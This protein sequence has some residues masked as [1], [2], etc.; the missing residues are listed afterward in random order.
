MPRVLRPRTTRSQQI[1]EPESEDSSFILSNVQVEIY[2]IKKEDETSQVK[3]EIVEIET[4]EETDDDDSL[5]EGADPIYIPTRIYEEGEV[6]DPEDDDYDDFYPREKK[7]K[8]AAERGNPNANATKQ[9]TTTVYKWEYVYNYKKRK[10]QVPNPCWDCEM[11]K[12]Q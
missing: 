12:K 9:R 11:V 7:Y 8:K 2:E 6:R 5:G 1:P 10:T 4:D 3:Q